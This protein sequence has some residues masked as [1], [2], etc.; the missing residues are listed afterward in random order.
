MFQVLLVRRQSR[1]KSKRVVLQDV[2]PL[3][4]GSQ[5]VDLLLVDRD[6]EIGANEFHRVQ[7]VLEARPFPREAFDQAV[8]GRVADVL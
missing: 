5:I 8:A 6:P 4:V 1:Q 2:D 3:M 7:F